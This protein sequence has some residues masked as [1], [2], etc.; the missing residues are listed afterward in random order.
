[1]GKKLSTAQIQNVFKSVLKKSQS[2]MN[3]L[4][5][6]VDGNEKYFSYYTGI[7]ISLDAINYKTFSCSKKGDLYAKLLFDFDPKYRKE[8][9]MPTAV[10]ELMAFMSSACR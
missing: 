5:P 8:K 2:E 7:E 10:K 3:K 9:N 4:K 6:K 1:M